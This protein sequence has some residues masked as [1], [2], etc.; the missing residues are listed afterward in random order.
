VHADCRTEK[1]SFQD[2]VFL[3]NLYFSD[4]SSVH[5]CTEKFFF[6]IF[7]SVQMCEPLQQQLQGLSSTDSRSLIGRA[8]SSAPSSWLTN[9]WSIPLITSIHLFNKSLISHW[10]PL[11]MIPNLSSDNLRPIFD[12]IGCRMFGTPFSDATTNYRIL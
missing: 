4:F 3:N 12:H 7:F 5:Y 6:Q 10:T 9:V 11:C 2:S 8:P 1:R